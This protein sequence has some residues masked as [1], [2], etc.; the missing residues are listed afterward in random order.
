MLAEI[1]LSLR[2]EIQKSDVPFL[3]LLGEN[4]TPAARTA[5]DLAVLA[6]S[7]VDGYIRY[8]QLHPAL[9]AVNLTHHIM[10]GMGQGGHFELYP[11]V[12]KAI[13]S[14][15]SLTQRE[16]ENLW[17]AFRRAVITLRF[18]PSPRISGPHFMADEYLRQVGVPI[19]F[20]DDLAERMLLFARKVGIPDEFDPEALAGWQNALDSKL[21]APFSITARK[22]VRMDSQAYYTRQFL[23]IYSLNGILDGT[24]NALEKSMARA[25]QSQTNGASFRRAVLPYLILHDGY[26]GIFMP[27]GDEREYEITVDESLQHVR[28]SIEDKFIPISNT[29]PCEVSIRELNG[30]QSTRYKLWEDQRPNRLLFFTE[31]GRFRSSAQL[32]QPSLYLTPG[33]YSVLS[34]FCPAGFEADQLWD[35]PQIFLF[36][37][38]LHPG[39]KV[40]L[41]NGPASIEVISENQP[42]AS[43]EGASKTTKEG[44][45]FFYGNTNLNVEFPTE[46]ISLAGNN[47]ILRLT[48]VGLDESI[49]LP[50]SADEEGK[51]T[52]NLAYEFSQHEWK[53]GFA[54]LVAEIYRAGDNRALIRTSTFYWLGL[55]NVTSSLVFECDSLPTNIQNQLNENILISGTSLKPQD[56]V[57]KTLRVV[58]KINEKRNQS[59]TWN[60]PG[61]YVEIENP[62]DS[63]GVARQS[64]AI[65]SVE[66]VSISSPKQIIISASDDGEILMGDW[67]Q[68]V[69][70]SRVQSKRFPAS[71]LASRL[72][73][74]QNKL[75]YRNGRTGTEVE[76]LKLVQPH[77]VTNI[78]GKPSGGQLRIKICLPKE[79]E[80]LSIHAMDVISGNDFEVLLEANTH[81]NTHH[82]FGHAQLMCLPGDEGGFSAYA[83]FSLDIWPSGA[84]I[85]HFDGKIDGVW[86]HLENSRQDQF[87][88]GFLCDDQGSNLT[89]QQL[90]DG[91]SELTDKESLETLTRVQEV[92]LPC[93]AQE[94]WNSMVWLSDMWNQL[95]DKWKGREEYAVDT[96]IP[97]AASIPPEDSSPSWLL[98]Q[99][100]GS[101]N[102]KIFCLPAECYRTVPTKHNPIVQAVQTLYQFKNQYPAVFP[103]LIN[104]VAAMGF[105]NCP[106]VMRG[107]KPNGYSL[108]NYLAAIRETGSVAS[109]LYRLEDSGFTPVPGDFLGSLHYKY[110]LRKLEESYDLCR[111]GND[112]RLGQ[113]IL[114]CNYV[115][116]TIPTLTRD[117]SPRLAGCPPHI[118]PWPFQDG[119]GVDD[120][121]AQR[122]S[123]LN[124]MAH[125]LSLLAYHCRL[126]ARSEGFL[127]EFLSKLK[128]STVP[129]EPALA[130]MI[131]V[132]DA[133]FAYYLV[134]WELV[135]TAERIAE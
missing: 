28:A 86:G 88:Y 125:T 127:G 12:Q 87:A 25:F 34:R 11:H 121:L 36:S 65:G 53:S 122:N 37:L 69:Q 92:M 102:P 26:L 2:E 89:I 107:G 134:L 68:Q 8:L 52:S 10:Q 17:R 3:G 59:L 90:L 84:W 32:N 5:L 55:R 112:L 39:K 93:Y 50:F 82:R 76:L 56:G 27:G 38:H 62:S 132:G 123:N 101:K 29:L 108:P 75:I 31:N 63:G 41:A 14:S 133:V 126:E 43:W 119:E 128:S 95:L 40:S 111:S 81:Q 71:F 135:I 49:E 72:T 98:Q 77:F 51:F 44:V 73:S 58:F 64:R 19:A 13:G 116:R 45:E 97:L 96:L 124:V 66:S 22:A 129:I 80:A 7:S 110:A 83:F 70:F 109:D 103:D 18:V 118:D 9:F 91:L 47:F 6:T 67:L 115:I 4:L 20:A 100:I 61:V 105:A 46:W 131:Q 99:T 48:A 23:R 60:V 130:F 35:D 104:P 15:G 30:N 57:T 117:D 79:L 85:F 54:R 1:E 33:R 94:A 74:Q 16:K 21:D 78:S 24:A 113:V 106:E 120:Y 114:L 42:F